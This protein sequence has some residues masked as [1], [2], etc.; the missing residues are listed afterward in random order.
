MMSGRALVDRGKNQ[1]HLSWTTFLFSLR[2]E[3]L[4]RRGQ[5]WRTWGAKGLEFSKEGQLELFFFKLELRQTY[6]EDFFYQ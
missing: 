6:L 1:F 2:A 4:G 5:G 3:G